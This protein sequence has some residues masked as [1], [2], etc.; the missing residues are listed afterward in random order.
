M[1]KVLWMPF[2]FDFFWPSFWLYSSIQLFTP[3]YKKDRSK[4]GEDQP[5]GHQD[6]E[7]LEHTSSEDRGSGFIQPWEEPA[8]KAPSSLMPVPLRRLSGRW[9]QAATKCMVKG[10]EKM[11]KDWNEG[12]IQVDIREICFTMKNVKQWKRMCIEDVSS[13]CLEV[14]KI[15][16]NKDL[17]NIIWPHSWVCC[18]QDDPSDVNSSDPLLDRRESL[19]CS[20][21]PKTVEQIFS[22]LQLWVQDG[23]S[24]RHEFSW[25]SFLLY[26][27]ESLSVL[28][29]QNDVVTSHS[30][31]C[32]SGLWPELATTLEASSPERMYPQLM[33]AIL[34]Q[35]TKQNK[36]NKTKNHE[37]NFIWT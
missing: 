3:W 24:R 20:D 1:K 12:C 32:P 31:I 30:R 5:K 11:D 29:L 35:K 10:Q 28:I 34:H 33:Q 8:W 25:I 22:L 16:L 2:C 15:C 9:S 7:R 27:W 18:K 4:L 19:P 6:G 23:K 36:Q 13:L 14:F 17:S 26:L 37:R 21:L